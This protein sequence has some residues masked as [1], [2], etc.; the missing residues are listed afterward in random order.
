M[1]AILL[2]CLWNHANIADDLE[3]TWTLLILMY[4]SS[5]F[6]FEIFKYTKSVLLS[7]KHKIQKWKH[8]NCASVSA[9]T[10]KLFS[11]SLYVLLFCYFIALVN[12]I[13]QGLWL[14]GCRRN[15][16]GS[17]APAM[18]M[19]HATHYCL[20]EQIPIVF[21]EYLLVIGW[22]WARVAGLSHIICNLMLKDQFFLRSQEQTARKTH[23]AGG[24]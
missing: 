11:A 21:A 7:T 10:K 8:K 4:F 22:N 19:Q 2:R 18:V 17:S 15:K 14:V 16:Q 13:Q 23:A 6:C 3:R 1:C 12:I 5:Y 24:A 20:V 9:G